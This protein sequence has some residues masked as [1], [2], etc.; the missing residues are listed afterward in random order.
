MPKDQ[1]LIDEYFVRLK[2]LVDNLPL[3]KLKLILNKLRSARENENSI[4]VCGN[5]GSASTASH[6][7]CDLLKNTRSSEQ[8]GM[9]VFGLGDNIPTLTAFAND[10]GYKSIFSEPIRSLMNA[11]DILIA[12]SASGNSPNVLEAVK[13]AGEKGGYTIGISGFDGGKIR[14]MVDLSLVIPSDSMER[15]EDVHLVI[16]HI[17]TVGLREG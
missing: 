5:G 17:L 15:I 2:E 7:V 1:A 6:M 9:R 8:K 16:N 3:D 11:Q 10:E 14:D 13:A 12:L 4:F